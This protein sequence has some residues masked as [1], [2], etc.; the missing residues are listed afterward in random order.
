MSSIRFPGK[1]LAPF[2]GLPMVAHVLNRITKVLD[3]GNVI[4]ATSVEVTDDPLCL[5]ANELGY[6]V[7]RGPLEDV[8]T[9]FRLCLNEFPCDWF[10][11]VCADSPLLNSK[12]MDEMVA[13]ITTGVDLITNVQKRTFPHG[14]S[15]ELLKTS[16]FLTIDPAC[17]SPEDREH[18][19]NYYYSNTKNFNI[20]NFENL[21]GEYSMQNYALDTIDD[22]PRLES[23]YPTMPYDFIPSFRMTDHP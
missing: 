19:T 11:R 12:L 23:L 13:Q 3:A 21:D 16:T 15:L 1:V 5:Y 10:F 20:I 18:P 8:F 9:R 17:L 14:H 6:Q 7:F 22:V 2:M 4:M